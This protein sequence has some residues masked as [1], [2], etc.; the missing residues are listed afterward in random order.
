MTPRDAEALNLAKRLAAG[1]PEIQGVDFGIL[2]S[3][4]HARRRV[5]G[6]RFHVARKLPPGE[7]PGDR[8][9]PSQLN[10]VACDVL[11][12]AYEPHGPS[13]LRPVD[14]TRP[15]VS[16]GNVPRQATG[17]LGALV[18][19]EATGEPCLLSNWHV[20]CGSARAQVG[21]IISQP[22]PEH[23]RRNPA[24]PVAQLLR[25]L[26]LAHGLDA[27][28]AR[29]NP[30]VAFNPEPV[31]L[32]MA[33]NSVLQPQV[34]MRLVKSG[35]ISGTTHAMIDGVDGS[36]PMDYRPFGESRRWMDGFRLVPDPA[37]PAPEVSLGGDSGAV[38][39]DASTGAG[40]GLHFAGED[41]LGP[42]AE[43]ALAHAL[44][45][46]FERLEILPFSS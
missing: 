26:N 27:A 29:C 20:L 10:G 33:L 34:G 42:L 11:E 46:V 28:I 23:L 24:R 40:V 7:L 22:G 31:D 32:T 21:D 19:D 44:P 16:I 6:I 9:L 36:Y 39:L 45:T 8:L 5:L 25:W 18:R 43:Y 2:Y 30:G 12:A 13:R 3:N 1:R 37:H 14:P 15:G 41:G 17:T 35:A 4:G 38:W